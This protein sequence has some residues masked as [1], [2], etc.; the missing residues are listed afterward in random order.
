[1]TEQD[2]LTSLKKT[3]EEKEQLIAEYEAKLSDHK[4]TKQLMYEMYTEEISN[5]NNYATAYIGIL[6]SRTWKLGKPF[7]WL[8]TKVKTLVSKSKILL[9]LVK[10]IKLTLRVGPKHALK[11]ACKQIDLGKIRYTEISSEQR[12]KEEG[13]KFSKDITFSILVPLYNTPIKYLNDMIES[14]QSQTY[15]KWELCLADGSDDQHAE[16]SARVK[17]YADKDPRIVYKKLEENMGISGNTNACVKMSTGNFVSL[18]DHDD[19]LHPSALYETMKAICDH[20]ADFV[21]TDEATFEGNDITKIITIH[22]KPDYAVD[23]LRANNYICHFS[24][25]SREL[26]GKI[27]DELF[28]KEYDGSQDHDM[29]LR[30][31]EKAQKVFH[32]R[33]LLYLWRSHPQSVASDINSKP[34]AIAAGQK[35][36]HDSI[37]RTTGRE[38]VVTSSKAF[39][40]IYNINY[41]LI[42]TPLVSIIIPNCDHYHDLKRCLQSLIA[43]TSYDNYE[44][45]IM[46]NNSSESN[47]EL[48]T[49]YKQLQKFH[50]I[51]VITYDKKFNY[52][53]INNVGVQHANGKYV[54]LLNNDVEIITP[55][56]IEQMLMYAQRED[57][58]AVGAKLLYPDRTIQHA[59]IIIGM[60][61]DRVA[62]HEHY[63]VPYEELGYMGRMYYA[64]NASAVTAACLLIRKSV[65]EEVGGLDPEFAV[66][67]NDIDFCLKVRKAGYLNVFTPLAELYH[68]ESA[69]RGSDQSEEN[70]Q[71]FLKE[72]AI[73]KDRWHDFL[74]EG[75]PYFNPNFSLD[76]S[77]FRLK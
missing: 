21:Y 52:S 12:A 1:M 3:Q 40:T 15:P 34:Y 46:E 8:G 31:T 4:L 23:N 50:K 67:Y 70:R 73:F 42:D 16:V 5:L 17:E 10:G 75:D 39:P 47:D 74:E 56:W 72:V 65:Y 62:G 26:L 22:H 76:H 19:I 68:Y 29:V 7:R 49:F 6:N 38:C 11:A 55:D 32:V 60:G 2:Y 77:D 25:F 24:S 33:K 14:V 9:K 18:F 63:R 54:L 45:L 48:F 69:S 44:I 27:G 20:D 57:V 35:A 53:D 30:L 66:A 59:G 71:R 28:R 43:K 37:V 36:V 64:R 41:E 13:T 61:A 58:G 51:R